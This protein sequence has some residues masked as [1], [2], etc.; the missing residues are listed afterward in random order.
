[1]R[2]HNCHTSRHNKSQPSFQVMTGN[3]K[4]KQFLYLYVLRD[5]TTAKREHTLSFQI[6]HEREN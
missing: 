6:D 5:P 4:N 2:K 1:M 3:R